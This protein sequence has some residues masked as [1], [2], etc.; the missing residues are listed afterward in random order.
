MAAVCLMI[1]AIEQPMM[2]AAMS[3]AGGL[4]GA[5]ETRSP[6]A[7]GAISVWLVRVPLAWFLAFGLNLGLNG[8]WLTMIADWG[9]RTA[10]FAWIVRR[11][12][13]KDKVL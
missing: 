11:G 4:R 2:G 13:W 5:G 12:R 9:F 7:V 1:G 8:L 6:L 3:F 10:A